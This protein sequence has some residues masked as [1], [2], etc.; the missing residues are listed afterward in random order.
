M[1]DRY[2]DVSK[3]GDNNFWPAFTLLGSVFLIPAFRTTPTIPRLDFRFP[4]SFENGTLREGS[5]VESSKEEEKIIEPPAR[6]VNYRKCILPFILGVALMITGIV[7]CKFFQLIGKVSFHSMNL[8]PII[9][10]L[11]TTFA[12][13]SHFGFNSEVSGLD[14]SLSKVH[15]L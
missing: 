10:K 13:R 6:T 11:I 2:F 3:S 5:T 14:L 9:M 8:E 15:N 7:M 12:L 4:S 1:P